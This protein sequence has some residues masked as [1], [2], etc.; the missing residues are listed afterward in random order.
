MNGYRILSLDE[1]EPV[2][3][4][5]SNLLAVRTALGFRA[6]GINA[7]KADAG[8]QLVP[9]HEED[10]GNEELYVVVRGLARFT[11]GDETEAAPAGTL[12]H[13]PPGVTRT[14]TAEEDGTIVV[15]VGGTVGRPF[16]SGGWDTY[17]VADAYRNQGRVEE[18]RALLRRA[19]ADWPASWALPYN[20]A[21]W[22]ALA[23][24]ADAGFE[25]LRNALALN[26]DEVR[27]YM[28]HDA[29]LDSLRDDPR[30]QE[31]TG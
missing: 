24:N 31:L 21:C 10:S 1:L 26:E 7:W 23:G 15:A 12:V 6:A 4:R 18:G 17:A 9:P 14:A 28:A 8:G 22:E 19:M 29:D 11:V 13:V 3:Y 27:E 16:A 30:W 25:H 5:G 20:A 2:P